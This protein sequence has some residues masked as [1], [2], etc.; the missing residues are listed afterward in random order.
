M[1]AVPLPSLSSFGESPRAKPIV[2]VNPISLAG[3]FGK[4]A[5]CTPRKP[6]KAGQAGS[7]VILTT[8]AVLAT[9]SFL[10]Y[11]IG[12][13]NSGADSVY[14]PDSEPLTAT[15]FVT[16]LASVRPDPRKN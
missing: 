8:A 9:L 14:V 13:R 7:L 5:A 1:H 6:E 16:V 10:F 12:W 3:K 4:I 11:R 2:G 15:F